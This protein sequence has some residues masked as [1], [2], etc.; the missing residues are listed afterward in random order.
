MKIENF[1]ELLY[2]EVPTTPFELIYRGEKGICTV[3]LE[4]YSCGAECCGYR[5]II[6]FNGE[7]VKL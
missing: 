1:Y 5:K 3:E 7:V 2:E 4:E 6:T